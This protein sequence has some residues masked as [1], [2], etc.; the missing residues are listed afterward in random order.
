MGLIATWN[1]VFHQVSNVFLFL[2]NSSL[3]VKSD[4]G[5]VDYLVDF[6]SCPGRWVLAK[7]LEIIEDDRRP[8]PQELERGSKYSG[9]HDLCPLLSVTGAGS[10]LLAGK[11]RPF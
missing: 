7:W 11:V 5:L 4:D 6:A 9:E 2:F 1:Y 8:G 10:Y 3:S